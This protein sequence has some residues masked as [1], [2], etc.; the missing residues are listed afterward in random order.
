MLSGYWIPALT[1][2]VTEESSPF[3]KNNAAC[4]HREDVGDREKAGV[5]AQKAFDIIPDNP[6]VRY[7]ARLLGKAG[8]LERKAAL[9]RRGTDVP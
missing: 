3:I 5:Q 9:S 1:D 8:P 6:R 7:L 2:S 4:N